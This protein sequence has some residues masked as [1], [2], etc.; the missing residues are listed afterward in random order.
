MK[1]LK[2]TSS[3]QLWGPSSPFPPGIDPVV[4]FRRRAVA[5]VGQQADSR[6]RGIAHHSQV[7]G[8]DVEH[9]DEDTAED[10][11]AARQQDEQDTY[12]RFRLKVYD[13]IRAGHFRFCKNFFNNK[14]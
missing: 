3:A 9:F 1:K 4:T 6:L 11:Q 12:G 7:G 14:N 2:N 10:K 13:S 5:A 8:A